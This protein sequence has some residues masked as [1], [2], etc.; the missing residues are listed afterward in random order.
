MSIF[1]DIRKSEHG[2][3]WDRSLFALS[4]FFAPIQSVIMFLVIGQYFGVLAIADYTYALVVCAPLYFLFNYSAGYYLMSLMSAHA[5][6]GAFFYWRVMTALLSLALVA[7]VPL[8]FVSTQSN[9]IFG[10]WLIK[11]GEIL[12]EP[13][14]THF[15]LLKRE[16]G[17]GKIYFRIEF[18]RFAAAQS[19]CWISIL[20]LK[21]GLVA[22]LVLNGAVSV[23]ISFYFLLSIPK[24]RLFSWHQQHFMLSTSRI[25][26]ASLPMTL[27]G[28]LLAFLIG[29]PRLVSEVAMTDTE[30]AT[31]G[32]AHVSVAF[33]GILF[34]AIWL[35]KIGE[36]L[37][38]IRADNLGD[39]IRLMRSLTFLFFGL[40]F[41]LSVLILLAHKPILYVFNVPLENQFLFPG[42]FLLLGF[43]HVISGY[44]DLLKFTGGPWIEVR[45]L[46]LALFFGLSVYSII[47]F[48]FPG[49][50]VLSVS[51]MVLAVVIV[52]FYSSHHYLAF[53]LKNGRPE[54]SI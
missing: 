6:S 22:L 42:M 41:A 32:L 1:S 18:L 8:I 5:F 21:K 45:I 47:D 33:S 39:A 52:Q 12:I 14:T 36:V 35:G 9:V 28:A 3:V 27:S 15:A 53:T 37:Q 34:N 49:K 40:L 10:L 19:A 26:G 50:W 54:R 4:R 16:S 7:I 38:K 43:Q 25:Y 13:V 31:F 2:E 30:Q 51:G 24:W 44:R 20:L 46:V 17:R 29:L 23:F 11:V 48:T